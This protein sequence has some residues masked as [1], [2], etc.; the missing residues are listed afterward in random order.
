MTRSPRLQSSDDDYYYP[1]FVSEPKSKRGR[2]DVPLWFQISEQW[3]PDY[4]SLYCLYWTCLSLLDLSLLDLSLLDLSVSTGPVSVS[5]VTC[6]SAPSAIGIAG[7]GGGFEIGVEVS[8]LVI[9]LNQR[10]AVDAFTKGGNLTLGGNCT[11]AVG[12]IGRNVEADVSIRSPA[13]VF[14]YCRSRGLFAGISL[15]GSGLIER[16]DTNRKYDQ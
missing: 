15:E 7:L 10:R 16:K 3:I 11:V 9:I 2:S 14:T 6:W 12:P 8:D 4:T 1:S 5:T 13:A